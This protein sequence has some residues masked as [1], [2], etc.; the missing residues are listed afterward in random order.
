MEEKKILQLLWQRSEKAINALSSQFGDRLYKLALNILS[1]PEDAE[2]AVNDTYLA[3]WDAI[4][5]AKPDP[6]CAF[7]YKLGRNTALNHLRHRSAQKRQNGY[8]LCLEELSEVLPGP[9]LQQALDSR[10]LGK[11]IDRFLANLDAN[12][13]RLFLRRYW[14]GDS[15]K[16]LSRE[17]GITENVISVRLH[18][19]RK[20]L[21]E[22]LQQEGFWNEA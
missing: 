22:H 16:S 19:I 12:S 5:P 7:V 8:D 14:Y 18:R 10:A 13:R 20:K 2:E 3:V 17:L 4:P 21:K 15:V 6:L 1:V 9:D 11:Q